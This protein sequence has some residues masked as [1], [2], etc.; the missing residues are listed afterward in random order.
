[1]FLFFLTEPKHMY[2]QTEAKYL[3]YIYIYILYTQRYNIKQMISQTE[4]V[5]VCFC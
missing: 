5:F 3:I 4:T 1:M 2:N